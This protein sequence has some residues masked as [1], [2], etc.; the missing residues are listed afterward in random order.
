MTYKRV[1]KN[2]ELVAYESE[3]GKIELYYYD[4]TASGNFHKDY[5]VSVLKENGKPC[6]F[7]TLKEAKE[8]LENL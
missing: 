7:S 8:A 2:N 5:I 6:R 4:V 3:A 1:Y